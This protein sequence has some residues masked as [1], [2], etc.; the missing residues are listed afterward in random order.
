MSLTE[1]LISDYSLLTR[2]MASKCAADMASAY[3]RIIVSISSLISRSFGMHQNAVILQSSNLKSALCK[4]KLGHDISDLAYHNT[5][6]WAIHGTGQGSASSPSIF[7]FISSKLF[8]C[9]EDKAKGLDIKTS[10]GN[11]LCN[12]S[13]MGF[14]DDTQSISSSNDNTVLDL[15]HNTKSDIKLWN[16]LLHCSGG[17]LELTKTKCH[18]MKYTFIDGI[19][20]LHST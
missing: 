12:I 16:D 11:K 19:P 10:D 17:K 4:I 1:E 18:I 9:Y 14:V 5:P 3:D 20:H 7:C 8:E 6:L 15:I 2:M 13:I